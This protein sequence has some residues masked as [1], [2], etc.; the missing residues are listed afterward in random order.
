MTRKH[1]TELANLIGDLHGELSPVRYEQLLSDTANLLSRVNPAFDE[2]R[3]R[4][5][6]AKRYVRSGGSKLDDQN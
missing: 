2:R 6:A 1:L 4:E 5:A 3:F